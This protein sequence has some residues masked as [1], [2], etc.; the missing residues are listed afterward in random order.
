MKLTIKIA[1]L[2]FAF[3]L[4]IFQIQAQ[5]PCDDL[6]LPQEHVAIHLDRNICLA[7]ETI[8]FKAWCFLDGQLDQKMSKV[9][10]VEIFDEAQKVIVQEKF[11][12]NKNK[13]IGSI[14]IPE[15][16]RSK[17]YFL[18][19]YT[20]YMR[21]F[22]TAN[23]HYQQLT[24]VNPFIE[25]GSIQA[26][27]I[28][29]EDS[30]SNTAAQPYADSA[31]EQ[32]LQI[33]LKKEKYEAREQI[34]FQ[35]KSLKPIIADLSTVVRMPGLGN[36]PRQNVVNQNEWLLAAC[37]E[38]PFC[39]QAYAKEN[40]FTDLQNWK[41]QK[42][43]PSLTT[44][45][46]QWLPETRGLA[47]SGV[48]QNKKSENVAGALSMV[49]VLQKRP[50]LYMGT[51]DEDG[52]FTIC[53]HDMQDQKD[54]FV[55]T[56]NEHNNVLIRNDFDSSFPEMTA[57]PLQYD[58]TLHSLLE[59]LNLH[60]QLERNFPQNKREAVFK[61]NRLNSTATNLLAPDRRIVLDDFIKMKTMSEVFTEIT[62]GVQ[63]RKKEGKATLSVFNSEQQR[64]YDSPLVLLDNVPVY[65]I[66][67]L[68]KIDPAKIEAIEIFNTDYF[69]GD[70][71]IGAIISIISKTDNFAAYQWG[72][73]AAFTKFKT[74]SIAQPFE[75]VVHEAKNHFPD[76]R[77]VLYWQPN[78]QLTQR[79]VSE[80]IS[81]FAPDRPGVYEILVQGFTETGETCMGYITFEVLRGM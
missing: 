19:A 63:L 13:A 49:S 50:L 77:P 18:K 32:K 35:I 55:G 67:E 56:P 61:S 24:I 48:V 44:D 26:K 33:K 62:T 71:T 31:P 38:D 73:Q 58:S 4:G 60:Q 14:Q 51:T 79:K 52:A 66:P 2:I 7:G 11:L 75:Q 57:V 59:A 76:F 17:H 12:L 47:I 8:W 34:Y 22:S 69:L 6:P 53:L 64:M 10:Y 78:I 41:D 45:Q 81:I 37:L 5:L 15:D 20:R 16:V 54:L 70:Y 46:L 21:N 36:Q 25:G 43:A 65:D 80:S 74:F 3:F 29:T 30:Y 40:Q 72:E 68:L 27:E 28:G 39:R 42:N 1:V 9:L 23:F